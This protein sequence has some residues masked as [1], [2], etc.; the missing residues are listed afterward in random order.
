MARP[1]ALTIEELE[2]IDSV[3]KAP[4]LI[5]TLVSVLSLIHI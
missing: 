5:A 4:G 2:K 3:W 1:K